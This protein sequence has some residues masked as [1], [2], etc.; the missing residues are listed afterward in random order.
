MTINEAKKI[1]KKSGYRLIEKRVEA[2]KDMLSDLEKETE[3]DPELYKNVF[4][5]IRDNPKYKYFASVG[6]P[7]FSFSIYTAMQVTINDKAANYFPYF[8]MNADGKYIGFIAYQ[9]KKENPKIVEEIKTFNF[10]GSDIVMAKD[11]KN[12]VD[13]LITRYDQVNWSA[14]GGN[15]VIKNYTRYLKQREAEGYIVS[16]DPSFEETI[17][18][19]ERVSFS[20]SKKAEIPH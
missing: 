6:D 2:T 16:R 11:I 8:I 20:I 17:K 5:R 15:S 4:S 1:V 14:Y 13:E 19:F 7:A 3:K 9:E 10:V 18:E 12:L